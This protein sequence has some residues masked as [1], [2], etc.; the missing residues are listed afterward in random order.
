MMEWQ[1]QE[2]G[3][4]RWNGRFRKKGSHDG[5]AG[6]G[7]RTHMMEWQVQERLTRWNDR[8]R[9]KGSHDGMAGTG[10]RTHIME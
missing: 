7:R 6:T 1:V 5:M 4:S 10:R 8:Y 9:K 3:L 2:E